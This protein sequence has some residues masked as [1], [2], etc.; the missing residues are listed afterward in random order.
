MKSPRPAC[1]LALLLGIGAAVLAM[2]ALAQDGQELVGDLASGDANT[3]VVEVPATANGNFGWPAWGTPLI[4]A[5]TVHSPKTITISASG[6][7]WWW[8]GHSSG[9]DGTFGDPD[10]TD[11][12]LPLSEASGVV[13]DAFTNIGALIGAFIPAQLVHTPGFQPVDQ[14][15]LDSGVGISPD[16]LF[17]VGRYN[18]IRVSGPGTLYLGMNDTLCQDNYGSLTVTVTKQ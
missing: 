6:T 16:K 4:R 5:L 7:W 13:A 15:K 3:V 18:V 10:A 1:R 14:T 17:F 8:T 12:Q 11:Y 9:P 2:P